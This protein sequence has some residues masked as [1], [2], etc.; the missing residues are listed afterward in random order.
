MT[1][2]LP[3]SRVTRQLI[4]FCGKNRLQGAV[5]LAVRDRGANLEFQVIDTV[6]K[7]TPE[8]LAKLLNNVAGRLDGLIHG[9]ARRARLKEKAKR[10]ITP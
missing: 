7:G 8:E 5:L 9:L 4:K 2:R 6:T 3:H 10:I 1:Q